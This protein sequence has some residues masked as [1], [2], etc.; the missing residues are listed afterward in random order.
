MDDRV[1][2]VIGG[3][4]VDGDGAAVKTFPRGRRCV[5]PACETVLS[6]YN[7]GPYCAQHGGTRRMRIRGRKAG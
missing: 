6:V 1:E 2:V 7:S 4:R 3:R 5:E